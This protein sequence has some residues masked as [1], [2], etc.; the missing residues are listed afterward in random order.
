MASQLRLAGGELS[1]R[2]T[3]QR[4]G[5]WREHA[6]GKRGWHGA[7]DGESWRRGEELVVT[8]RG[9]WG[10]SAR[11]LASTL[12]ERGLSSSPK[13]GRSMWLGRSNSLPG[14]QGYWGEDLGVGTAGT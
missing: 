10:P 5:L 12:K 13:E 8:S 9:A 7:G 14:H 4:Q 3:S 1:G 6:G 2:E 11:P